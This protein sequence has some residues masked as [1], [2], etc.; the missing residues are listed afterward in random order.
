MTISKADINLGPTTRK[1]QG[2]QEVEA[3]TWICGY[4]GDQVS[5]KY[6]WYIG[7]ILTGVGTPI[8]HIRI[9]PSCNAPTFF[10]RN[11]QRS[12]SNAPGRPVPNVPDELSKLYQEAR[13]SA[14]AGAYTA[15]C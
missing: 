2:I 13:V 8:S 3:E 10:A 14:G 7:E 11:G 4:C 5:S 1:W 9:C 12:P 15:S 6:G